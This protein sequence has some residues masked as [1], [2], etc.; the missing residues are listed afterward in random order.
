MCY[1]YYYYISPISNCQASVIWG[2]LKE[3]RND[4]K[5]FLEQGQLLSIIKA[6]QQF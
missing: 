6:A 5:K 3:Y 4:K 2:K 1:F